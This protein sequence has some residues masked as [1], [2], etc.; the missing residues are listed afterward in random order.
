[1]ACEIPFLSGRPW[2]P[3]RFNQWRQWW[4]V[5]S[6]NVPEQ[7]PFLLCLP[8]LAWASAYQSIRH[9]PAIVLLRQIPWPQRAATG[10]TALC[11]QQS[12]SAGTCTHSMKQ[13]KRQLLVGDLEL[14][15]Q[16]DC[17]QPMRGLRRC[18]VHRLAIQFH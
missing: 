2:Q 15:P 6:G 4:Q 5:S 18:R 11:M 10:T 16:C 14:L 1:M 9:T 12:S 8:Y 13:G 3:M 7:L 17:S